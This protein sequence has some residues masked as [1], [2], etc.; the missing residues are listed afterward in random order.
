MTSVDENSPSRPEQIRPRVET[1]RVLTTEA[2]IE[3]LERHLEGLR[4]LKEHEAAARL[5]EL[6]ERSVQQHELAEFAAEQA[7]S[8][9]VPPQPQERPSLSKVEQPD[10]TSQGLLAMEPKRAIRALI[11]LATKNRGGFEK[12]VRLLR[13]LAPE[14]G[15]AHLL[16]EFHDRLIQGAKEQR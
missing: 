6:R 16:D 14:P 10:L 9:P 7:K 5:A 1:L 15:G 12:V 11:E 4:A 2:K 8:A 3:E 13:A